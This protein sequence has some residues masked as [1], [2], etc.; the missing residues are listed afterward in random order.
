MRFSI[1][2]AFL[3]VLLGPFG[4]L[5]AVWTFVFI[6]RAEFL[7]AVVALGFAVFTLGMVA[8]MV[9][10]ASR[11]VAPRITCHDDGTTLRP[12]PRVDRYLT[13]ST[14]GLFVAMAVYAVFAPLDMLDIPTPRDDQKYFVFTC[15]VGAV[16]GVF[17]VRHI[18][19]QRGT[20]RLR[21]SAGGIELGNTMSTA[22]RS[23]DELT[24]I[25]DRPRNGRKPS[26]TTYITT[27]GGHTR[28]LPSDW[29][30]PGG[31][32][33]RDLVRFYWQ[34]PEQRAELAD[35][36]VVQRLESVA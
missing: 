34:H 5:C 33:L 16:V 7:S 12:D 35:G 4:V 25:A 20:S 22:R 24:E 19:R 8:M 18:L 3:C 13:A 15:A 17:S 14:V 21:M 30:T 9:V 28:V 32:A 6:G 27:D 23:W 1:A 36:R 29:Y 10:V 2:T 11:K 31:H 26:G